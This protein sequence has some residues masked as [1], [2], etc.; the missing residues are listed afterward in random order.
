MATRH[1]SAIWKGTLKEGNGKMKYGNYEGN[2]TYKSRFEEGE[3]TNP[4]EL[5]GAAISGCYSMFLSALLSNENLNP[6]SIDVTAEVHL[7][8]DETGPLITKIDLDCKAKVGSISEADFMKHVQKAK[9]NCPISRLY[10]GTTISV[11]ATL[12][13]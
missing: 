6:D 7:E 8:S 13:Q 3:G 10:K 5:V 4:E 12:V 1:A 2:Y 9:E 11:N